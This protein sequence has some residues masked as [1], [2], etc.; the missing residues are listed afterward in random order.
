MARTPKN[1]VATYHSTS[2]LSEMGPTS[3]TRGEL[4][5]FCMR[6]TQRNL[7]RN[8]DQRDRTFTAGTLNPYL[9]K[10]T[11]S[12]AQI[13]DWICLLPLSCSDRR[14]DRF[15]LLRPSSARVHLSAHDLT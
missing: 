2:L 1:I 3:L 15:V 4:V 10:R 9:P 14:R 8:A 7:Q 6:M 11:I 13:N 5:H 12:S